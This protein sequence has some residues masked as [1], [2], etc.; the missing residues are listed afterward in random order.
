MEKSDRYTSLIYAAIGLY[1]AVEG[2]R[3]ELGTLRAPKPGILAD[4]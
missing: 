2:Y 1:I 4:L 3:L